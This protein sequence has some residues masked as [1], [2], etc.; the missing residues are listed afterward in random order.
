MSEWQDIKTAPRD[1]TAVL[2]YVPGWSHGDPLMTTASWY[3][4]EWCLLMV[5]G[6]AVDSD[7]Y[8]DPTHWQPLPAPPEVS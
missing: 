3:G 4:D 2:L 5:G 6:Y 1:G 8:P 7:V